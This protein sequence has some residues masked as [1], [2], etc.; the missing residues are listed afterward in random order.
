MNYKL[1]IILAAIAFIFAS[2]TKD[3][4][5]MPDNTKAV[6]LKITLSMPPAPQPADGVTRVAFEKDAANPL[7]LAAK[8]KSGDEMVLILFQGDNA[9]W[10]DNPGTLIHKFTIPA[11]AD[12]Q[13]TA[14]LTAAAGTIDLSGFNPGQNLKYVVATGD[15][16]NDA[17]KANLFGNGMH[18]QAYSSTLETQLRDMVFATPVQ[19]IPFPAG[20]LEIGG[21]LEWLTAVLAVKFEIAPAAQSLKV[22]DDSGLYIG[23]APNSW[24]GS[25]YIDK[26]DLVL[27]KRV[28]P[29]SYFTNGISWFGYTGTTL[30]EVLDADGF[31]YFAIPADDMADGMQVTGSKVQ[32]EADFA[33]STGTP[34]FTDVGV[35]NPTVTIQR[36]KCYGF[37][38][39]VTDTNGDGVPE[40]TKAP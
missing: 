4:P 19:E 35:M 3:N 32:V 39:N 9:T 21:K 7:R 26:Y 22:K 14:D 28:D 1:S 11:S 5:E 37:K 17:F 36:G 18:S 33:A 31:R 6:P 34:A 10:K 2:C 12:W 20:A 23:L 24:A 29:K 30:G 16:W 13:T 38:I 15:G 8:W 40:F 27:R 25:T